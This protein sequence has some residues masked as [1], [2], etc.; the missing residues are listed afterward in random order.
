MILW[1]EVSTWKTRKIEKHCCRRFIYSTVSKTHQ[2]TGLLSDV[3]RHC[4]ENSFLIYPVSPGVIRDVLLLSNMQH[5]G[6]HRFKAEHSALTDYPRFSGFSASYHESTTAKSHHKPCKCHRA[7]WPLFP[8]KKQ[9]L[10]EE[11]REAVRF[12]LETSQK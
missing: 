5:D 12:H 4:L 1:L 3:S 6:F 11:V 9:K 2:T 10:G 8:G 7:S